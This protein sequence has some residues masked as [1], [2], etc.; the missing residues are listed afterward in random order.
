MIAFFSASL[1]L[2]LTFAL[3]SS[4]AGNDC[5]SNVNYSSGFGFGL[6]YEYLSAGTLHSASSFGGGA[7]RKRR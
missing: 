4:Q 7:E 5:D 6:C 1:Q 2:L 3:Y